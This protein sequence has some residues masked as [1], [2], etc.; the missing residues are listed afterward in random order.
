MQSASYDFGQP[1]SKI[2]PG[3]LRSV[4]NHSCRHISQYMNQYNPEESPLFHIFNRVTPEKTFSTLER[5]QHFSRFFLITKLYR[6]KKKLVKPLACSLMSRNLSMIN[7]V[8][9]RRSRF[10]KRLWLFDSSIHKKEAR[11]RS[12]LRRLK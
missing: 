7:L 8:L 6:I 3:H 10:F 11:S 2:E 5:T 9:A 4:G 1:R 12:F